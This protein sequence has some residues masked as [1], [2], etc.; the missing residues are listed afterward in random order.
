MNQTVT[1]A[2]SLI[3]RI[4]GDIFSTVLPNQHYDVPSGAIGW[5]FLFALADILDGV[6][7]RRW[8]VERFIV[9]MA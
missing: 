3:P 4:N 1:R 2:L 9:Y 6:V 5:W 8:N 7:E